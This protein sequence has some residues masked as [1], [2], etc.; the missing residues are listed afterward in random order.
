[1]SGDS[2][3]MWARSERKNVL[4]L[5]ETPAMSD[6]IA[7]VTEFLGA[8]HPTYVDLTGAIERYCTEDCVWSNTGLPT[9]EG[10]A[11]ML[12]FNEAFR[13]VSGLGMIEIDI[14]NIVAEGNV[15]LTERIDY[16]RTDDGTLIAAL[17]VMGTFELRDGQ[18]AAWRD[19]YD[20]TPLQGKP[21]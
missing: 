20:P 10:K 16:L 15:V 12:A 6:V 19:Y 11:A 14:L 7:L 5:C 17:P 2:R 21:G 9:Q 1:V 13:S 4:A 3:S 18:I 8:L